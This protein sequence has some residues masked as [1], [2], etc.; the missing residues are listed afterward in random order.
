MLEA[1]KSRAALQLFTSLKRCLKALLKPF[2]I[3]RH[4]FDFD[5]PRLDHRDIDGNLIS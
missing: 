5:Q 4:Q 2:I 1:K 3:T